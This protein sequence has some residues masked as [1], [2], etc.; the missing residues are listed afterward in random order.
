MNVPFPDPDLELC[1]GRSSYH[2]IGNQVTG[3]SVTTVDKVVE[4]S[5]LSLKLS[6]QAAE[7]IV[8]T[9]TCQ[10]SKEKPINIPILCLHLESATPLDSYGSNEGL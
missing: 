5:P 1:V 10:L 2:L 6:M 9:K 3:Y 8:L 7:L 4:V